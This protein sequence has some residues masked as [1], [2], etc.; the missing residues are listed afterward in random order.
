MTHGISRVAA[1]TCSIFSSYSEDGRS[2]LHLVQRSQDSCLDRT[3]TSRTKLG[4]E[5]NTDA[6][7]GGVGN[8]SPL[9]SFHIDI[10]IPINFH[11]ESGLMT[12]EN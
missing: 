2:K 5:D 9:S 1:G 7:G 11:E 12:F 8:H 3:D 4:L 6:S 10:E